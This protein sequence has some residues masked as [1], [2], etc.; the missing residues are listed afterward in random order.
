MLEIIVNG[1]IYG[2][3]NYEPLVRMKALELAA[4]V[5]IEFWV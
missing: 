1:L 3:D 5:A 4:Q 2:D